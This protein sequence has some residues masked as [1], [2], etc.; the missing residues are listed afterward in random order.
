M[1]SQQIKLK[2]LACILF[3]G[4]LST[5]LG[6]EKA[7]KPYVLPEKP[8]ANLV[9]SQVNL[10]EKYTEQ[11]Y[12]NLFDS[13]PVKTSF[14]SNA[15]DLSFEAKPE[16]FRILMNGGKNVRIAKTNY[17]QFQQIS[18]P[19]QFNY[20]WDEASGGDSILLLNWCDKNGMGS[21][22]IYL[23][24]RGQ[25]QGDEQR[26]VQLKLLQHNASTYT[27]QIAN[28]DGTNEQSQTILKDGSKE[29]I[30]V[31]LDPDK[32][33]QL[34]IEPNTNNWQLCFL[35]YRWIYYEFNPPLFYLVT[36]IFI[37]TSQ[38]EVAVDSTNKF[39]DIQLSAVDQYQYSSKRDIIG[40]DWKIYDFTNGKYWTR[41]Y[42]TYILAVKG[43]TKKYYKLRFTDF[44]SNTGVKG[45]P[46]FEWMPLF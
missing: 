41:K 22:T 33:E 1:G 29:A 42:V 12:V 46:K 26:Y 14:A 11:V 8:N 28:L 39:E 30:L 4:V 34:N 24:D 23:V 31:K 9:V 43:P 45:S 3:L 44:Y 15:W 19:E 6:C 13:I 37:N 32:F 25:V 16:G 36:G 2:Q 17:V 38:I 10:G 35:K 5:L 21:D 27:I 18:N 7:D 40:Y 20:K